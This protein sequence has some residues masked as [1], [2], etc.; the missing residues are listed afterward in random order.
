M[1]LLKTTLVKS[2]VFEDSVRLGAIDSLR[3]DIHRAIGKEVT[4]NKPWDTYQAKGDS[5]L[6][7]GIK[8][9][10]S[11]GDGEWQGFTKEGLDVTID[12]ERREELN[13]VSI[14][15]MQITAKGAYMPDEVILE[16]S[17]N[18]KNFKVWGTAKNT[19]P[20]NRSRLTFQNFNFDLEGKMARYI[21]VKASNPQGGYLFADEIIVY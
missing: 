14:R 19:I 10:L 16:V 2:A 4:Y 3:V 7:N 18:G 12:F 11:Y 13:S 21:R 20:V 9:G 1:E 8:G 5:T 15:F 17:D 6:V